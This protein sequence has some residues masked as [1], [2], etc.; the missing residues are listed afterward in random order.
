MSCGRSRGRF[1]TSPPSSA[2]PSR[3]CPCG[4]AT[5]T[6]SRTPAA[7]RTGRRTN[8]HPLHVAK[9]EEIERYRREGKAAIG[10]L[11][12]REFFVLG[13]ALYAG[14][15]SKTQHS[16]CFANSDPR[17]I[18]VYVTWLRH[19]F[20]IDE[21]K[22]R[23][24]LYLHDGLDLDAAV[25]YWSELTRIPL[26]SV[27]EAVSRRRRSDH[28]PNEARHGLSGRRVPLDVSVAPCDGADRGGIVKQRHSG[29][30]QLAAA[31]D[32]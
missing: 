3:A 32:C 28:P 22:L 26:Q 11:S 31:T 8:P 13:L 2:C 21:S 17:M 6:S 12:E 16:L 27:H 29:V 14:E 23:I 25:E 10:T 9:L 1:R 5:S 4:S 7:H 30:A 20:E 15:G 24:K 18:Y 19:F